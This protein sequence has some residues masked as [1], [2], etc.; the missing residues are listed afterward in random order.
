MIAKLE[1]LDVNIES[2]VE[3]C[4]EAAYLG[5]AMGEVEAGTRHTS[6]EKSN[7]VFGLT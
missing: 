7:D 3:L 2:E 1:Q 5:C 6:I 4:P